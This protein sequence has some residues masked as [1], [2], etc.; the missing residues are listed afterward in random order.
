MNPTLTAL[1]QANPDL[2]IVY[3]EYP[4][5][6]AVSIYAAKAA[7]SAYKQGKYLPFHNALIHAAHNLNESKIVELAKASGL[8]TDVLKT[9]INS[10]TVENIIKANRQLGLT[11]GVE[12]TPA[13]FITKT[14]GGNVDFIMGAVDRSTI[15]AAINK[16]H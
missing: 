13:L 15:Q 2:R 7:L 6:G 3:K 5:R 10:S 8:D 1:M 11:I 4:I 12:G 16:M 14:S 9:D